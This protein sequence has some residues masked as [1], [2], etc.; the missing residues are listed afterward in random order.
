[1]DR[2]TQAVT[3]VVAVLEQKAVAAAELAITAVAAVT[4][5]SQETVVAAAARDISIQLV[6]H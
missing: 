1:M 3:V 5:T 6:V 2:N 4:P